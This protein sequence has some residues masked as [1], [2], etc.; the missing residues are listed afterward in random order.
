MEGEIE[1]E[2]EQ[3][4]ERELE[5]EQEQEREEEMATG[6]RPP[7]QRALV[8]G[9]EQTSGLMSPSSSGFRMAKAEILPLNV[10][11][12]SQRLAPVFS[13]SSDAAQPTEA[14]FDQLPQRQ[15]VY[16]S[17]G[18]AMPARPKLRHSISAASLAPAWGIGER[19]SH[20]RSRS[21]S[22]SAV[23]LK[24]SHLSDQICMSSGQSVRIEF[25]KEDGTPVATKTTDTA[26]PAGPSTERFRRHPKYYLSG[27]D[28]HFL[29]RRVWCMPLA[30]A[31]A[32]NGHH[33]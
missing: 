3:E 11:C 17:I 4:Q 16:R 7:A 14:F 19:K 9:G 6:Y 21:L 24:D 10:L 12:V 1:I 2:G 15:N 5:Q 25:G 30:I 26:T 13:A 33:L 28:I 18:P 32:F 20:S 29:V 31:T 23:G 22:L 8:S 27:G